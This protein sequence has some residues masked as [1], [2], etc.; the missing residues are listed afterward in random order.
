MNLH[1]ANIRNEF[2]FLP[3]IELGDQSAGDFIAFFRQNK[4]E[5]ESR[6]QSK[7]AVKFTGVSIGSLDVFQEI[8]DAISTRFLNYVDGNS[9][10]TK[11]SDHVYTSTEYDQTKVITMHNEL[12]YSAKW[13]NKLFFSCLQPAATGGETLLADSREIL[14]R[15]NRDIVSQ[16]QEKGVMYIRNLHGGA[17][18]G[19]SWQGT[20]ETESK[21]Q[22][23]EYCQA[24][25]MAFEWRDNNSLRLKQPSKGIIRHRVTNELVWFNQIDQFHPYQLGEELYEAMMSIY[26][27]PEEFPTYVCFGDGSTISED[28]VKDILTSIEGCTF[29]PAWNINELL[30]VDNELMSHGRNTFTGSRK[31]LVAMSE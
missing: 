7:G 3:V 12:S 8:V 2:D 31:V 6:L 10:R 25:N 30:I 19:P 17:G 28:I 5:I 4:D 9:P 15:M 18:V 24:Y 26:D 22:V 20:F 1:H 14:Q 23:E 13:P 21:K 11:L 27:S 29:A 16:V